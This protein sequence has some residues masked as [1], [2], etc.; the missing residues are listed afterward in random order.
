MDTQ[1]RKIPAVSF[2]PLYLASCCF[3]DSTLC[4]YENLQA[5]FSI[6]VRAVLYEVLLGDKN[7]LVF[8]QTTPAGVKFTEIK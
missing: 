8:R 6:D 5:L 1:C 3:I 7:V 2:F 4:Y